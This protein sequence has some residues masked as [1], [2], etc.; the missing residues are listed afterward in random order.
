MFQD[1]QG[2][3]LPAWKLD[4]GVRSR[5]PRRALSF[6]PRCY[7]TSTAPEKAGFGVVWLRGCSSLGR[8][9]RLGVHADC[10]ENPT[11]CVGMHAHSQH[12]NSYILVW[13]KGVAPRVRP[14]N[15][16]NNSGMDKQEKEKERYD[17]VT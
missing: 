15:W 7:N 14:A 16:Q 11:T 4:L 17:S 10:L 3:H 9:F 6:V 5:R 13:E 2:N 8:A 12:C 1:Q